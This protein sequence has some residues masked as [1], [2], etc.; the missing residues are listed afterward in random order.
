MIKVYSI[1]EF[2][3][4]F[5]QVLNSVSII[6]E[7]V[8]F[9]E[10]NFETTMKVVFLHNCQIPKNYEENTTY[11]IGK[12][13]QSNLVGSTLIL[14]NGVER[15]LNY[16]IC[17]IL[18]IAEIQEEP[19]R[20]I[21]RKV[22]EREF[23]YVNFLVKEICLFIK[24]KFPEAQVNNRNLFVAITHD[25]DYIKVTIRYRISRAIFIIFNSN[26]RRLKNWKTLFILMTS[27]GSWQHDSV[28]ETLRKLN[29]SSTWF[30]FVRTRSNSSGFSSLLNPEYDLKDCKNLIRNVGTSGHEIALHASPLAASNSEML[31]YEKLALERYTKKPVRGVRIH[32]GRFHTEQY[33]ETFKLHFAYDSSELSN[34]SNTY[35]AG[36]IGPIRSKG[37]WRFPVTWMDTVCL[38]FE[39]KDSDDAFRELKNHLSECFAYNSIAIINLHNKPPLEFNIE[40]FSSFLEWALNL[41]VQFVTLENLREILDFRISN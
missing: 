32:S 20:F 15:I 8:A 33:F 4:E 3:S 28:L 24:S 36:Y 13:S 11:I 29:I 21:K 26:Y 27:H 18:R 16:C 40:L 34:T 37:A 17:R 14:Q 38:N 7:S 25:V 39:M 22:K 9:L 41:G 19:S 10:N 6:Q 23:P 30:F 35:R 5:I 2:S 31:R 1:C 12:C